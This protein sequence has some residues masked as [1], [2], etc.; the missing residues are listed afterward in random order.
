MSQPHFPVVF[1][2]EGWESL[3]GYSIS[4]VVGVGISAILEVSQ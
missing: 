1:V 3:T 4:E 2:S